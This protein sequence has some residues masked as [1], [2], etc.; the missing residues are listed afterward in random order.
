[1]RG[2]CKVDDEFVTSKHS[3]KVASA[4]KVTDD[5]PRY[6][7]SC[8]RCFRYRLADVRRHVVAVSDK[9]RNEGATDKACCARDKD[10]LPRRQPVNETGWGIDMQTRLSHRRL[11]LHCTTTFGVRLHA[12]P[13]ACSRPYKTAKVVLRANI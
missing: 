10:T 9:R 11:T 13:R 6:A 8:E 4:L 5:V 1:M 2:A 3:L 7:K 12:P